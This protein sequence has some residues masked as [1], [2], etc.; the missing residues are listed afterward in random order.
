MIHPSAVIAKNAEI[1]EQHIL[2]LSVS[3]GMGLK[4]EKIII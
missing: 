1:H 2:A 3:L 4:L